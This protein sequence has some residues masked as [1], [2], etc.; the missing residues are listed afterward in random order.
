MLKGISKAYQFVGSKSSPLIKKGKIIGPPTLRRVYYRG[1]KVG[2]RI[3]LILVPPLFA[4]CAGVALAY[5]ILKLELDKVVTVLIGMGFCAIIASRLEIGIIG[6]LVLNASILH[7]SILPK[8][9][10]FGFGIS[11]MLIL[12]MVAVV[13]F[14]SGGE[15]KLDILKSPMT[16]PI[17]LFG[18]AIFLSIGVSYNNNRLSTWEFKNAY[19][20]VRPLFLYL[21]FFI[22]AFGIRT[23][24]GLRRILFGAMLIAMIVS[25]LLIVQ[26]FV[27][28]KA[29][30]F[31]GTPWSD[32]RVEALEQDEKVTRS[33]PPGLS[34]ILILFPVALC[35]STT[36]VKK[37]RKFFSL[38]ALIIGIGLI[39]GFSRSSW[40]ST[41]VALVVIWIL[42]GRQLKKRLA[43]ISTALVLFSITS[44]VLLGTLAPGSS[45]ANFT[46]ATKERFLSIFERST[47]RS[48][49][50]ENRFQEGRTAIRQIRKSPILGIGAGNPIR[51]I[52]WTN[53]RGAQ[54]FAPSYAIHNSYLELWLVYGILGVIS[55]IW[56][57]IAFLIRSLLLYLRAR[58]PMHKLLGLAFFAGYIASLIVAGAAM[59]FLH[60]VYHIV[61]IAFM[62]GCVE[63]MWR[64]E[65]QDAQSIQSAAN[66]ELI[67]RRGVVPHTTRRTL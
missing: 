53:P 62:W 61:S 56:I 19:N 37:H 14:R 32:I 8:P 64:L 27:G 11:E 10:S 51:Y 50:V 54:G 12:F 16:L 29:K 49:G 57:S 42:A 21:L 31:F 26:Y 36:T 47:L 35:L 3:L 13:I 28:T 48:A 41:I 18:A 25:V 17:L 2:W 6:I 7:E 44:A 23:E 58:N 22:I 40:L 38:A 30:I 67:S 9:L 60:Q 15:R 1:S 24:Q 66:T 43:I 63:I 39:F 33:M 52:R 4:C 45:G 5:S 46:A 65:E 34:L 59:T 20:A 55:F